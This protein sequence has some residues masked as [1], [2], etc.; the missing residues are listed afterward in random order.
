MSWL[1]ETFRNWRAS[2]GH[3]PLSKLKE[4]KGATGNRNSEKLM[5]C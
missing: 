3:I 5:G 4:L 2:V 1:A